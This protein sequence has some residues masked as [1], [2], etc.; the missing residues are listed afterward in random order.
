MRKYDSSHMDRRRLL[1]IVAGVLALFLLARTLVY[2][3]F[4][5]TE[6][7]DKEVRNGIEQFHD[8]LSAGDFDR[9]Y[10]GL[11]ASL[12]STNSRE[13]L[14][15]KMRDTR[16]RWGK[17]E[18]VTYSYVKVFTNRAP[19]EVRAVYNTVFENGNATEMFLF[20]R[21]GSALRMA[22][23][24]ITPGMKRPSLQ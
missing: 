8:R 18:R 14:V 5:Y 22:Y 7:D 17:V 3:H 2:V 15:S 23:Y 10:D 20:V 11:D 13:A 1:L 16:E 12:T 9:I 24:N 4:G 6:D 21:R 19:A